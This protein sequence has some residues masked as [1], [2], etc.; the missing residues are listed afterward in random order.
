MT[1]VVLTAGEYEAHLRPDRA[2]LCT[3]LR[4]RGEQFVAWPRSMMQFVAGQATGIPLLH[5]WANRLARWGYDD[6][7]L[8]GVHLP[9]DPNG[10]PIHGNLF[11]AP[12]TVAERDGA[13]VVASLDYGASPE[14]LRAFP[15]PHVVTVE[16]ALDAERGLTLTTTVTPTS[17]AAVP[18][19]FGWHPYVRLPRGGRNTWELRW[20][21]CAHVE[22]DG[23]L[24]PTGTRTPQASE[25]APVGRRTFDD[26]YALGTDRTFAISA[27]G[28]TLTLTFG[29]TYPFAMLYVPPRRQLLAIEPMTAE[30]DA[31]DRGTA[32]ICASDDTFAATFTLSVTR[33]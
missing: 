15:F 20:P 26:H 23:Q 30:I 1:D 18:I 33:G 16:A 24:I 4:H 12:F 10:L 14:R 2:M 7:D 31:L 3:S 22:L 8:H 29:D 5:P 11:G 9:T 21:A 28:C 17:G 32:P 25:R 27:Q 13:R 19:S 6:V